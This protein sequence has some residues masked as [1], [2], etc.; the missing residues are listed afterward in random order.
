M[1]QGHPEPWPPGS[2]TPDGSR[3]MYEPGEFAPLH[4]L[5]HALTYVAPGNRY[6]QPQGTPRFPELGGFTTP[7]ELLS[8]HGRGQ[9]GHLWNGIITALEGDHPVT[10]D[11]RWDQTAAALLRWGHDQVD[12]HRTGRSLTEAPH[13]RPSWAID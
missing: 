9:T 3:A 12:R 8:G 5:G 13:G 10:E 6:A 1:T 4:Q 7:V 2:G 11:R